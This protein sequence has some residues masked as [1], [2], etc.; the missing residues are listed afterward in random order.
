M[1]E[2]LRL[3]MAGLALGIVSAFWVGQLGASLLF[4]V[5]A[6]D[7]PTLLAVSALL[8]AI[9]AAACYLPARRAARVDPLTAIRYE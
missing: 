5:T 8:T 9:A 6:T 7:P 4:G 2:G 3:A 1:G